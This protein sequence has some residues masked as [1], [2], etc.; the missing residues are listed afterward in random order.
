MITLVFIHTK[1]I[2]NNEITHQKGVKV[3]EIFNMI[4]KIYVVEVELDTEEDLQ[5][6]NQIHEAIEDMLD[7]NKHIKKYEL[8][9]TEK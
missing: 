2:I 5:L 8:D 4:K 1:S 6:E 9:I 7:D 3:K